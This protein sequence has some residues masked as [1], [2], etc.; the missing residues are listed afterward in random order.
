MTTERELLS[1]VETLKEFCLI[2]LGM[3]IVVHTN[4]KNL[5]YMIVSKNSTNAVLQSTTIMTNSDNYHSLFSAV[6][7]TQLGGVVLPS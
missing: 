2:L 1:I 3:K 7:Y 6:A 5:T 4:H